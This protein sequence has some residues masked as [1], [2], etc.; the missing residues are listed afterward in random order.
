M[1]NVHWK[2]EIQTEKKCNGFTHNVKYVE[3]KD[4]K[5]IY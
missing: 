3:E 1:F 5:R 2:T 4:E